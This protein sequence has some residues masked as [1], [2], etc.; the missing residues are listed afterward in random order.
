MLLLRLDFFRPQAYVVVCTMD[1]FPAVACVPAIVNIPSTGVSTSAVGS[2]LLL[3]K[4]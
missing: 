2:A 4:S 1:D 3:L